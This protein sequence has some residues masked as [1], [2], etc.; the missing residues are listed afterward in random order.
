M[1]VCSINMNV[2]VATL[3]QTT[4]DME[5]Q[6]KVNVIC[7]ALAMPQRFVADGGDKTSLIWVGVC[8]F[9]FHVF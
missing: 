4:P 2:I 3:T 9:I 8:L 7:R 1:R 6:M 5:K